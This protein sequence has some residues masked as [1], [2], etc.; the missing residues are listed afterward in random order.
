MTKTAERGVALTRLI[1]I[2]VAV[3]GASRL[4]QQDLAA[5]C[6]CSERTIRRDIETLKEAGVPIVCD[7]VKGCYLTDDWTLLK[8]SLTVQEVFA[9]LLAREA[10]VGRPDLPFTHSTET[11]FEKIAGLLPASLRQQLTGNPVAYQGTGQRD[12]SNAPWGQLLSAIQRRERLEMYYYTIGRDVYSTR[13]ID[14]YHIVWLGTTCQLIAYC[15]NNN[16]VINFALDGIQVLQPTGEIFTVPTTFSLAKHLEG[17]AGPMIGAPVEIWIRFDAEIAR[18]AKRRV[19]QFPHTLEPQ[20]NGDL[21]L[22]G[23][24]RGLDDIRKEILTWGRHARVLSPQPLRDQLLTHA[25]ALVTFYEPPESK[26]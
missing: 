23:T 20:P 17:A 15:Y 21:D 2:I 19:W 11:A 26:E 5:A 3:T 7:R 8:L 24:V 12:Y 18:W 1:Q 10:V 14:P 9:L 4:R 22:R 13:K 6:G 25:R 16:K